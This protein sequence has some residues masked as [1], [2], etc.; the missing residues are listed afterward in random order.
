VR[1]ARA[2]SARRAE[3]LKDRIYRTLK[4]DLLHGTLAPGTLLLEA[5][6]AERYRVSKTPVREALALLQK[7]RLV[8]VVPRRGYFVGKLSL[9]DIQD[10]YFLRRLLEPAATELAARL[11]TAA[12]L[13][14]LDAVLALGPLDL[15]TPA[16]VEANARFHGLIAR[17]S[18][19]DR[20]ATLIDWLSDQMHLVGRHGYVL[21]ARAE[22]VYAQHMELLAALRAHDARQAAAVMER[23]IEYTRRFFF[24]DRG[25]G[26]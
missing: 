14:D 23:H 19:N 1:N 21:P 10:I 22:E 26:M 6:L 24:A 4:R 11:V 15:N 9:K 17:A 3:P 16:F 20:L 2:R 13:A 12:E 7:D 25:E 18:R 8:E 5:T